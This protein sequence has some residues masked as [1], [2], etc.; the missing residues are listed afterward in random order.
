MNNISQISIFDYTEIE[1]LGD[2]E[3]L[4][5][6]LENVEDD[7]LCE[8]LEKER[9]NGRN[10]YPVRAM[11]NSIYAMKIFEHRGIESLRRELKRNSQLRTLCGFNEGEYKFLKIRKNGKSNG[12]CWI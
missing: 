11:L 9:K 12:R 10:D 6:F 1:N 8:T 5:L 4:K 3:K 7:E 2:L